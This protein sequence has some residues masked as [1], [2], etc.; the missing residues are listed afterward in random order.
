MCQ[1]NINGVLPVGPQVAYNQHSA[2]GDSGASHRRE[3]TGRASYA[4]FCKV[5]PFPFTDM[6]LQFLPQ[7]A[8]SAC[9]PNSEFLPGKPS[10]AP[11]PL[12]AG[13]PATF[14]FGTF[15]GKE[16]NLHKY[17]KH[18]TEHRTPITVL[19]RLQSTAQLSGYPEHSLL[20]SNQHH[21]DFPSLWIY[22]YWV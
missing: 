7:T 2:D 6:P 17:L 9:P 19:W 14:N 8:Y 12:V 1:A 18:I 11:N 22:A 13:L 5:T 20:C 3:R 21:L 15:P 16:C 4:Y 10:F